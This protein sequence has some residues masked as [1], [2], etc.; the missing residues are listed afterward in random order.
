MSVLEITRELLL[1]A[2]ETRCTYLK[3]TAVWPFR[4]FRYL[5]GNCFLATSPSSKLESFGRVPIDMFFLHSSQSIVIPVIL[6]ASMDVGNLSRASILVNVT[7]PGRSSQGD[8]N[9]C[10]D[11]GASPAISYK[12]S[13]ASTNPTFAQAFSLYALKPEKHADWLDAILLRYQVATIYAQFIY[14]EMPVKLIFY[15]DLL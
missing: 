5:S 6:S 12:T 10:S 7:T 15:Y 9:S 13:I 4:G 1:F 8:R 2:L 11:S 3:G 14:S